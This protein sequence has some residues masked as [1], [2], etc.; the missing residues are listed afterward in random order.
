VL[1]TTNFLGRKPDKI[2]AEFEF[3]EDGKEVLKCIN[4][5]VPKTNKYNPSSEQCRI[6]MDKEICKPYK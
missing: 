2:L 5:Q 3:T 6:T 1:V 4:G